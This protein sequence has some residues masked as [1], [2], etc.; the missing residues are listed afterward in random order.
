MDFEKLFEDFMMEAAAYGAWGRL[1][2]ADSYLYRFYDVAITFAPNV[3]L[4]RAFE[5]LLRMRDNRNCSFS[6]YETLV[7]KAELDNKF[8]YEL[9]K[10]LKYLATASLA[11]KPAA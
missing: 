1:E 7:K 3:P 2:R 10:T 8:I 9:H 6:T 4:R 5:E 11:E